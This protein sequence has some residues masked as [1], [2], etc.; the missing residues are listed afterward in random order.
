MK[1]R[2]KIGIGMMLVFMLICVV[3][4]MNVAGDY[5]VVS[6][7]RV[8]AWDTNDDDYDDA[9]DLIF[10]ISNTNDVYDTEVWITWYF[11]RPDGELSNSTEEGPYTITDSDSRIFRGGIELGLGGYGGDCRLAAFIRW[12]AK[13]VWSDSQGDDMVEEHVT[14]YSWDYTYRNANDDKKE[15][16]NSPGFELLGAVV[17]IGLC[18]G[19]IAWRQKK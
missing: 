8:E 7:V 2:T 9:A 12:E 16:D 6:D 5:C 15:S 3:V 10:K 17:V 4:P 13:S 11:Y 19:V 14:L 18:V 1:K